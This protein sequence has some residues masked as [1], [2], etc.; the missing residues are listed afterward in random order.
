M[1]TTK[2]THLMLPIYM[3]FI[4]FFTAFQ[5]N[6]IAG[7]KSEKREILV[8]AHLPLSGIMTAIG[9]AQ[10]WAY[11][12][13]VADINK[14][15]GIY[16]VEYQ[17]KLPVRLLVMDDESDPSVVVSAVETLIKKEKV[18]FLLSGYTAVYGVI[19]GCIIA[20]I[21]KIYYHATSSF[22]PSWLPHHFTWWSTLL[23]F[24][25]EQS[26]TMPFE[27]WKSLPAEKR[28]R[29]PALIMEETY[30]A[31]AFGKLFHKKAEKYGYEFVLDAS[32]SATNKDLYDTY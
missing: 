21:N 12:A 26:V 28:P 30:D 6:A 22:I 19:P 31:M 13:A 4:V 23:F 14:T 18:D 5:C 25:M 16:V 32:I 24:G 27:I 11:E 15:G 9:K 17:K 8:G 10:K 7:V 3:V 1:N 2:P 29:R 20:E